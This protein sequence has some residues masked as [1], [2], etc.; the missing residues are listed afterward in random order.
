MVLRS[1]V[2][3]NAIWLVGSILPRFSNNNPL[4]YKAEILDDIHFSFSNSI[5]EVFRSVI[6]S[7]IILFSKVEISLSM[8]NISKLVHI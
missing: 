1:F 6:Y 4:K 7:Q 3:S 2:A 5:A 8:I